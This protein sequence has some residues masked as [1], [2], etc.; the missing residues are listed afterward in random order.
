MLS[1]KPLSRFQTVRDEVLKDWLP[2]SWSIDKI[3]AH[4]WKRRRIDHVILKLNSLR[5][6]QFKWGNSKGYRTGMDNNFG[7]FLFFIWATYLKRKSSKRKKSVLAYESQTVYKDFSGK[8]TAICDYKWIDLYWRNGKGNVGFV[9]QG[10][11]FL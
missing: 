1:G 5:K 6:K 3:L 11:I 9:K 10:L 7:R 8:F 2:L 4:R